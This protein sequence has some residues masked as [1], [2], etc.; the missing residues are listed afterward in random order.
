[1]IHPPAMY[2]EIDD[3]TLRAINPFIIYCYED[4]KNCPLEMVEF[5]I[6]SQRNE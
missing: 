5:I 3:M 2:R 1:M 4:C 6:E